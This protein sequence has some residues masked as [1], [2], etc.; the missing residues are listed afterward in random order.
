MERLSVK[1]R[2]GGRQMRMCADCGWSDLIKLTPSQANRFKHLSPPPLLTPKPSISPSNLLFFLPPTH[3][4][5]RLT[6]GQFSFFQT[7][8]IVHQIQ[9][10]PFQLH[11]SP[12]NYPHN[13]FPINKYLLRVT[14]VDINLYPYF[15]HFST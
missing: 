9:S 4:I 11:S 8:S 15:R 5:P 13:Y 6:S 12:L 7:H 3:P 2:G 1:R 14:H 10:I